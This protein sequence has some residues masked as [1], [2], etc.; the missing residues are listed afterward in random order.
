MKLKT[1]SLNLWEGGNLFDQ[2]V[3]FLKKE[4]PDILGLQE[5]NNGKDKALEKRLRSIKALNEQLGYQYQHFAPAFWY[6][7]GETKIKNGNAVFSRFPIVNAQVTFFDVPYG[8][9]D[10]EKLDDFSF[11]PR[12]LQSV[13]I[14]LNET[15]LN[16]FNTQGIWGH[17]GDDTKRRFKMGQ[18]IVSKIKDKQNVVLMGDFNLKPD[19]ETINGIEK[20][21]KNVFQGELTTSFNMRHKESQGTGF[22]TSVVDMIFVSPN[23]K[24]VD[25][26]CPDVDVSDHLPLVCQIEI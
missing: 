26:Y 19:T 17:H 16:V 14:Q 13:V 11:V 21:L 8:K 10:V 12:N 23:L 9:S 7:H 20:H 24:V 2:I 15:E 5:V 18:V 3:A 6:Q 22:A 4:Q 1:I 25:H